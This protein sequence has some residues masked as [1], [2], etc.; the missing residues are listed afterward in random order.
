MA[1][2]ALAW[3][4]GGNSGVVEVAAEAGGHAGGGRYG[5]RILAFGLRLSGLLRGLA[6]SPDMGQPPRDHVLVRTTSSGT[7]A[8]ARIG[9]KT[10]KRKRDELLGLLRP[11]FGRIEV[12]LQARKY[13]AAVMS[14]L[15]QRNGWSIAKFAGDRAPDNDVVRD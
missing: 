11:Q 1:G 2:L 3:Q 12:F 9:A 15:P 13:L 5:S 6:G 7:A 8:S 10:A 4:A 14:D